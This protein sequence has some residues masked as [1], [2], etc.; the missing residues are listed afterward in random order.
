MIK[1]EIPARNFLDVGKVTATIDLPEGSLPEMDIPEDPIDLPEAPY[2]E[3][4]IPED[5]I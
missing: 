2:L 1:K 3:T 5:L 4:D